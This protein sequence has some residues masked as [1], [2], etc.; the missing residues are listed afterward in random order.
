PDQSWKA[1]AKYFWPVM[2]DDD[3]AGSAGMGSVAGVLSNEH[4]YSDILRQVIAYSAIDEGTRV[5]GDTGIVS[6]Y[7]DAVDLGQALSQTGVSQ[8]IVTHATDISRAFVQFAGELA[9]SKVLKADRPDVVN[10]VLTFNHSSDNNSL[11]IDLSS[12]LWERAGSAF[13][14]DT[15]Q[16]R[17]VEALLNGTGH[18]AVIKNDMAR[19]WG[20]GD[21]GVFERVVLATVNSASYVNVKAGNQPGQG[22][23]T[24]I[25]SGPG[26]T[27]LTGSTGSDLI[28]T[29]GGND[30][31]TP[32]A[33]RDIVYSNGVRAYIMVGG[34]ATGLDGDFF[35]GAASEMT[36]D[37]SSLRFGVRVDMHDVLNGN[38]VALAGSSTIQDTLINV[39]SVVGSKY[40]DI[41]IDGAGS[42][43]WA[44]G[45]GNDLL[46]AGA[47][48]NIFHG[49]DG[50]STVRANASDGYDVV[51]YDRADSLTV[52]TA[53]NLSYWS[54][55]QTDNGIAA[56]D[57]LYSI[58]GFAVD[59]LSTQ[60]KA[61]LSNN[62]QAV[63]FRDANNGE[64]SAIA[65][66]LG[67]NIISSVKADVG[68]PAEL[69][70]FSNFN[71]FIGTQYADTFTL[72]NINVNRTFNGNLGPDLISYLDVTGSRGVSVDL[73]AGTA[74]MS[75]TDVVAGPPA[76]FAY[77]TLIGM[78]RFQGSRTD[79]IFRDRSGAD[80]ID[81]S[82]GSDTMDYSTR[83]GVSI[84]INLSAGI[85]GGAAGDRDTLSNIEH[86]ILS[87][88][89][90]S[91]F[92]AG[93]SSSQGYAYHRVDMGGGMDTADIGGSA[94]MTDSGA[95]RTANGYEILNAEYFRLASGARVDSQK[96]GYEYGN[97]S[98]GS[99]SLINYA[100]I[101]AGLNIAN[102]AVT[103]VSRKDN[104]SLHDTVYNNVAIVGSNY[105]DT[106]HVTNA[107]IYT[108]TG[109]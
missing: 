80:I 10:G 21:P 3:F 1:G 109:N 58:E 41:M 32:G 57:T 46:Y 62:V 96:I 38:A 31:I 39:A 84:T 79:D 66:K 86:F 85:T 30:I 64:A 53:S 48:A 65:D 12:T 105:G 90:D 49:G 8:I 93:S 81:G 63:I 35:H 23:T 97:S 107:K 50:F 24:L 43:N 59:S 76:G 99:G 91:L 36:V 108:G 5:F 55:L 101:N 67:D 54:A 11:G 7:N 102:D 70:T 14:A 33:G 83:D 75:G 19:T 106:I 27:I 104:P 2:Y 98:G 42:N 6:F 87:N 26:H 52:S 56:M 72:S 18:M 71:S 100:K 9:M 17:L 37:Y 4:K 94:R 45:Q 88:Y 44:G 68:N 74:W 29:E 77:D 78:D 73:K 61:D 22:M 16:T 20:I 95:M 89:N 15:A 28:L 25:V 47:G 82:S 103:T 60:A 13:L 34:T 51:Y 92:T 69:I 40:S